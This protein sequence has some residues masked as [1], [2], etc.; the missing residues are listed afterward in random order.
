MDLK[1]NKFLLKVVTE[2]ECRFKM[3]GFCHFGTRFCRYQPAG[4][5]VGWLRRQS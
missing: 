2:V 1:G 4:M 5:A 3:A